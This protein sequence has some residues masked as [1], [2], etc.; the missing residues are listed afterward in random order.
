M[1]LGLVL[2][3]L[4][5]AFRRTLHAITGETAN[6]LMLGQKLRLPDL[7][8]SILPLRDYQAHSEYVQEM[9]K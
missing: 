9:T 3:Q 5:R 6:M 7:L 4:L 8:M 2:S 1:R